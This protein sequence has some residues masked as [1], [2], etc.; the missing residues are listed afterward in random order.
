MKKLLTLCLKGTPDC[1]GVKG[2]YDRY[3]IEKSILMKNTKL[4]GQKRTS[5]KYMFT[6]VGDMTM[7]MVPKILQQVKHLKKLRII[8]LLCHKTGFI[9]QV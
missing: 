9:F 7:D 1:I 8:K 5:M 4:S 6:Q 2:C 3:V